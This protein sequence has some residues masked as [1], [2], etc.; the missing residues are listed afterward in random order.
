MTFGKYRELDQKYPSE[1]RA[2]QLIFRVEPVTNEDV[3][4]YLEEFKGTRLPYI[5]AK[6]LMKKISSPT[7]AQLKRI[8]QQSP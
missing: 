1:V 3:V 4:S 6:I 7:V 2:G 8:F 5:V